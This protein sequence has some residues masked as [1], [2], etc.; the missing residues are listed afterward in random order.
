MKNILVIEDSVVL[1]KMF[2]KFLSKY[3]TNPTIVDSVEGAIQL[4]KVKSFD[5][6]I[7][8]CNLPGKSGIDFINKIHESKYFGNIPIV[9]STPDPVEATK[10]IRKIEIF[11]IKPF[12]A[13]DV[14][15]LIGFLFPK[16]S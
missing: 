12:K 11:L 16:N 13:Q 1:Q 9:F 15:N 5:A 10:V 3:G 7:T 8:D 2:S 6:I 14:E 4:L